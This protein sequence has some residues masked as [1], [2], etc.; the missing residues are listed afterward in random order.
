MPRGRDLNTGTIPYRRGQ[1]RILPTVVPSGAVTT[2]LQTQITG[3][4][5]RINALEDTVADHEAR[6]A[7]LEA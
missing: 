6:I 3:L 4:I 1:D 2:D 7:A 5:A